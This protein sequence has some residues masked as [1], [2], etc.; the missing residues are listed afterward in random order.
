MHN[1]ERNH[2]GPSVGWTGGEMDGT[3]NKREKMERSTVPGHSLVN[4]ADT[5]IFHRVNI[6]SFAQI[7]RLF[8]ASFDIFRIM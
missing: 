5:C 8:N 4:R 3:T 2:G 7:I 6:I 1:P